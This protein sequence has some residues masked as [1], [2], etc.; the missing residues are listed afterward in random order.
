[1]LLEDFMTSISP[2]PLNNKQFSRR[3]FLYYIWA[4][5]AALLLAE[6]G[7]GLAWYMSA[8]DK[9]RSETLLRVDIQ[10]LNEAGTVPLYLYPKVWLCNTPEGLYAFHDYCTHLGCIIKWV[11]S[12][13]RFECPCH[14]AKFEKNGIYIEGPTLRHL[15]SYLIRVNTPEGIRETPKDGGPVDIADAISIEVD[16]EVYILGKP[17]N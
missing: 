10:A 1:M 13:T 8:K 7:V 2:Q 6:S 5:S 15:D 17:R 3:E 14:A 16:L 11:K 9:P 4:A 12:N